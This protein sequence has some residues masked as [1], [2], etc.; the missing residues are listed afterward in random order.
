MQASQTGGA[1][2]TEYGFATLVQCDVADRADFCT[3]SA[4]YASFSVR[5][6]AEAAK[7][8]ALNAGSAHHP[9]EE[10]GSAEMSA[11]AVCLD[12]FKDAL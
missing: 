3:Q 10:A 2:V 8:L 1:M 12:V 6:G 9:S 7:H 4:P 5:Y 11:T